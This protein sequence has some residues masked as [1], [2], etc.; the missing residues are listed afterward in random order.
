MPYALDIARFIAHG[1]ESRAP[2]PFRMSGE[3]KRIFAEEVYINLEHKPDRARYIRD[4]RLALLN[5]YVEFIEDELN[6]PSQARDGGFAWYYER[7]SKLAEEI[8]HGNQN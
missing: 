5:E 2:F 4:I 6:H 3:C 8:V 7:A 1:A